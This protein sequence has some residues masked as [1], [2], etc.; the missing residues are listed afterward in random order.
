MGKSYPCIEVYL[1]KITHNAKRVVE[2]CNKAGIHV[3]GVTK[4]FCA[5][6]PIVES[7]IKG[8]IELVG[9]SR[10]EN[11]IKIYSIGSQK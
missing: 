1:K 10:L 2:M 6:K 4:V 5:E 3:V 9:D 7:E 11:L 8:G